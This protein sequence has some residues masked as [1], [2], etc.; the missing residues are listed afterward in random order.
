M[1]ETN[2]I[3]YDILFY[4]GTDNSIERK[5]YCAETLCN[6]LGF[7]PDI[8][9]KLIYD[10]ISSGKTL[11]FTTQDIT[12]ATIVRDT[13]LSLDLKCEICVSECFKG[14]KEKT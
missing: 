9:V 7:T 5:Q 11:L 1:K 3:L 8:A 4:W 10:C 12:A 13:L 6:I 2:T 14:D